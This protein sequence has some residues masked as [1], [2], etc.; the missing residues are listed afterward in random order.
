MS[1]HSL[2]VHPPLSSSTCR[3]TVEKGQTQGGGE[4]AEAATPFPAPEWVMYL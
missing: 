3:M 2:K 4:R 1:L